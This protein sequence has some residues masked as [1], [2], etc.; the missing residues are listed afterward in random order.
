[1]AIENVDKLFESL[2]EQLE[3]GN[4]AYVELDE[5]W[6]KELTQRSLTEPLASPDGVRM[7]IFRVEATPTSN[8]GE[9][10]LN[11]NATASRERKILGLNLAPEMGVGGQVQLTNSGEGIIASGF[12]SQ[13]KIGNINVANFLNAYLGGEGLNRRY[14]AYLTEK[15]GGKATD[16][17]FIIT[18][19]GKL[20]ID[21]VRA[22]PKA[23]E[24]ITPPLHFERPQDA[25]ELTRERFLQEHP[26]LQD[27]EL[28][29]F[30]DK[31]GS[32]K[33]GMAWWDGNFVKFERL[34]A[35]GSVEEVSSEEQTDNLEAAKRLMDEATEEIP[36]EIT[37]FKRGLYFFINDK[38][39]L[40]LVEGKKEEFWTE[41]KPLEVEVPEGAPEETGEK[42][43]KFLD[44]RK[45]MK[46]YEAVRLSDDKGNKNTL[47]VWWDDENNVYSEFVDEGG[48][49]VGEEEAKP[50]KVPPEV[51][52]SEYVD[53][54]VNP[55][56]ESN[57]LERGLY[58]AKDEEGKIFLVEPQF[59]TP[60]GAPEEA[61]EKL[62]EVRDGDYLFVSSEVTGGE[63]K[64]KVRYFK[65]SVEDGRLK[66]QETDETGS[67]IEG[68]KPKIYDT[69]YYTEEAVRKRIEE[70]LDKQRTRFGRRVTELSIKEEK[71][72]SEVETGA[73]AEDE[74]KEKLLSELTDD[75]LVETTR[76]GL[77]EVKAKRQDYE[78][79]K[80]DANRAVEFDQSLDHYVELLQERNRRLSERYDSDANFSGDEEYEKIRD[81][82]AG[83][84]ELLG[85]VDSVGAK[86]PVVTT[87]EVMLLDKEKRIRELQ[88]T[89]KRTEQ[90][91]EE[92]G[93]AQPPREGLKELVSDEKIMDP[94]SINPE[95]FWDGIDREK[96][97]SL[98]SDALNELDSALR[99]YET[100]IKIN[101]N[102]VGNNNLNDAVDKLTEVLA[103]LTEPE[104]LDTLEKD[105]RNLGEQ[106][107]LLR[108]QQEE[109]NQRYMLNRIDS[110]KYHGQA[111]E[112]DAKSDT[113]LRKYL[114]VGREILRKA[115]PSE[116]STK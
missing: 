29:T 18:E 19:N 6:V 21:F 56:Q 78:A 115:F 25:L 14:K 10:N 77:Q 40:Q 97:D 84:S 114:F 41:V 4:N 50:Y 75:E 43:E 52:V 11:F 104:T 39:K 73:E 48:N 100:S 20:R 62:P 102:E 86:L 3:A 33:I 17:K 98:N 23:E 46:D 96:I 64:G 111:E 8:P 26:G 109:L 63:N 67:P 69:K 37:E 71:L 51:E 79:D 110:E 13:D 103:A 28:V 54:L 15:L 99:E 30:K 72:A 68:R 16:A 92:E 31:D 32:E 45:G 49:K 90:P 55:F 66:S 105:Y 95:N 36:G 82:L 53:E 1:M 38:G 35:D 116:E 24:V 27:Y 65:Y 93:K 59:E 70:E 5:R 91:E 80:D 74:S 106:I 60:V 44:L 9:V 88:E 89:L 101:D 57:T 76:Q 47:L 34:N 112:Y 107:D 42:P 87:Y 2:G 61:A 58:F 83:Q 81:K 113:L 22:T 108:E 7:K 12:T 85:K 94:K